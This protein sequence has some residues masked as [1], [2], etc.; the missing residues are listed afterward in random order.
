MENGTTHQM[1]YSSTNALSVINAVFGNCSDG[2]TVYLS[3]VSTDYVLDGYIDIPEGIG[4][5]G[6]GYN[7]YG[8]GQKRFN[9]SV[10]RLADGANTPLIQF[11]NQS[12]YNIH[13]EGIC[14]LGNSAGQTFTNLT[15][16]QAQQAQGC[17]FRDIWIEDIKGNG[18][19]L[20][21]TPQHTD[22]GSSHGNVIDSVTVTYAVS[23]QEFYGWGFFEDHTDENTYTNCRTDYCDNGFYLRQE[24]SSLSNCWA[25]HGDKGFEIIGSRYMLTNCMGDL[26]QEEALKIEAGS[27]WNTIVN[28]HAYRSAQ[29]TSFDAVYIKGNHNTIQFATFVY[30]TRPYS[31]CRI[32]GDWNIIHDSEMQYGARGI[33]LDVGADHNNIHDNVIVDV[34][35]QGIPIK[36]SDYNQVHHNTINQSNVGIFL[37]TDSDYNKIDNNEITGTSGSNAYAIQISSADCNATFVFYNILLDIGDATEI[38]DSGTD[39]IKDF[40]YEDEDGLVITHTH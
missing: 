17:V 38:N 4:F 15:G 12:N 35:Y 33:F 13:I 37:Y 3:P 29:N 6:G 30:E 39:T 27:E 22:V 16:I 34:T 26:Q 5:F 19:D 21:R 2:D 23:S 7:K 20:Y 32:T 11:K 1:E 40:N 31:L 24:L 25:V 36:T 9:G 28:F 14:L 8:V 18:I 10:L